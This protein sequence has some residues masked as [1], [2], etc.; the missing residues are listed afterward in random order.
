[1]LSGADKRRTI[2]DPIDV[3]PILD[4]L[5]AIPRVRGIEY[6]VRVGQLITQRLYAGDYEA[7]ST[8]GMSPTFL[9]LQ[10]HPRLPF[11]RSTFRRLLAA[12]AIVHRHEWIAR[13]TRLS[14]AHLTAVAGTE[15]EFQEPLL[16][17]AIEDGWSPRRLSQEVDLMFGRPKAG[18]RKDPPLLGV[19]RLLL[20]MERQGYDGT[21]ADDLSKEQRKALRAALPLARRWC[22]AAESVLRKGA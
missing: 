2:Q 15:P 17:Q 5:Y 19:A 18:K 11:A 4:E 21:P 9:Q 1:M 10:R 14:V 16:Q 20:Q 12:A 22:V 13:E 8:P 3:G 7:L 6:A